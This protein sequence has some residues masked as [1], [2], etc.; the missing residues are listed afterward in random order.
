[1][2]QWIKHRASCPCVF[3]AVRPRKRRASV[4]EALNGNAWVR[5]LSGVVSMTML[6][7]FGRLCDL[8]ENVQLSSDPDVL[9]WH[10]TESGNYSASRAHLLT[11]PCSLALHRSEALH[12]CGRRL[13]RPVSASSIG[14][15]CRIDAGPASVATAMAFSQ[16]TLASP[17]TKSQR[18]L[19]TSCWDVRTAAR[20]GRLGWTGFTCLL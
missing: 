2:A 13:R 7:E 18:Q 5:H 16:R 4:A 9:S 11:G 14:W 19:I 3:A 12:S 17:V 10:L 15:L 8:L 20:S 1:V 6:L